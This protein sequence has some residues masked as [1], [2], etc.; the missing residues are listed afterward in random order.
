MKRPRRMHTGIQAD[1]TVDAIPDDESDDHISRY[2]ALVQQD[3]LDECDKE[4]E[5][6]SSRKRQP[7]RP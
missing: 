2:I 5:A 3:F 6:T 7:H 4:M 1:G